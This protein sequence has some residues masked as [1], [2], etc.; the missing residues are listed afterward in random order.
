M[1]ETVIA[2]PGLGIPAIALLSSVLMVATGRADL[3]SISQL[4]GTEPLL[5]RERF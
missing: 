2:R 3:N 1:F 5:V 4:S